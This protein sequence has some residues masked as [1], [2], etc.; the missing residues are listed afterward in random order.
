MDVFVQFVMAGGSQPIQYSGLDFTEEELE[1]MVE[2]IDE[3]KQL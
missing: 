3:N 1:T 2:G